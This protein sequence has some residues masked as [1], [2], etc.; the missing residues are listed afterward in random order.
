MAQNLWKRVGAEG[1]KKNKPPWT[2]SNEIYLIRHTKPIIDKDVC[3]G[4]ADVPVDDTVFMQSANAVLDLLSHK[5][6]AIYSS[7]LIRC[8]S[9]A[10]YLQQE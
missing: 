8:S 1:L 2:C 7:P 5:V 6:D 4:Q 3:Y 9:L 10:K